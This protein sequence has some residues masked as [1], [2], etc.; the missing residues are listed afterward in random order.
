M[1]ANTNVLP[2][3]IFQV[4]GTAAAVGGAPISVAKT[5]TL[6]TGWI[7]MT[8]QWIY[9]IAMMGV[10]DCGS[11]LTWEQAKAVAAGTVDAGT[12]KALNTGDFAASGPAILSFSSTDDGKMKTACGRASQLDVANGFCFV[13]ATLTAVDEG[14]AAILSMAALLGPGSYET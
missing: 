7:K 5:G 11:A 9:I 8:E 3:Q 1:S 14:A 12:A 6:A 4:A 2:S 13:K 10:G